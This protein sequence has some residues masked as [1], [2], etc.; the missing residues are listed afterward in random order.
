MGHQSRAGL[1]EEELSSAY[2]PT[3]FDHYDQLNP[4]PAC[5]VELAAEMDAIIMRYW[6]LDSPL[7]PPV[8]SS[9]YAALLYGKEQTLYCSGSWDASPSGWAG[10]AR[11]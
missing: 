2:V 5:L 8:A 1:A 11:W 7:W 4:L 10:L 3:A 6:P 9:D